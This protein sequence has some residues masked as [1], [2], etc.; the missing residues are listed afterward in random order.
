LRASPSFLRFIKELIGI[1]LP[2]SAHVPEVAQVATGLWM[3]VGVGLTAKTPQF[4]RRRTRDN[5]P[6]NAD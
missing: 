3:A 5:P 6:A 1:A 2:V 4:A